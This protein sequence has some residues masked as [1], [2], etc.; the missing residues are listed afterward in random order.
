MK[1]SENKHKV[2]NTNDLL[3]KMNW[4]KPVISNLDFNMTNG[5][6]PGPGSDATS[7]PGSSA[8]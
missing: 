8:S 7:F 5:G 4:H 6:K 3:I 2:Q 1:E